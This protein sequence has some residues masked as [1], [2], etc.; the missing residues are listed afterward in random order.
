MA[1]I[2]PE[3]LWA[4]TKDSLLITIKVVDCKN[5]KIDMKPDSIHF[6]GTGGANQ[7][8]DV[9]MNFFKEII[10]ADSKYTVMPHHIPFV[11]KKKEAGPFWPR[12]LKQEGKVTFLKTDFD[13]WRDEN[14]SDS[15]VG[16]HDFPGMMPGMEG[17]DFGNMGGMGGMGGM[18]GMGGVGGMPGDFD[19]SEGDSDDEA[20]LPDLEDK[21]SELKSNNGAHAN[22]A[23]EATKAV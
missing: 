5:S 3:V 19:D 2:A 8:Y 23:E 14:D 9:T 12:L 7:E 18:P 1:P 17:M 4:H 11:I 20:E 21:K 16:H 6:K 13:K 22:G 15:E 10:P